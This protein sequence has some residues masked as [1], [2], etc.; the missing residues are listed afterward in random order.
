MPAA[1]PCEGNEEKLGLPS[2]QVV[3]SRHASIKTLKP[4]SPQTTAST[5]ILDPVALRHSSEKPKVKSPALENP[6]NKH[7]AHS[8][9]DRAKIMHEPPVARLAGNVVGRHKHLTADM[10]N[11]DYPARHLNRLPEHST[12]AQFQRDDVDEPMN[13]RMAK[14]AKKPS[15]TEFVED[16]LDAA[17]AFEK[18]NLDNGSFSR[19]RRWA[20]FNRQYNSPGSAVKVQCWLAK[21]KDTDANDIKDYM[22][23]RMSQHDGKAKQGD[24]TFE[25]LEVALRHDHSVREAE[26]TPTIVQQTTVCTWNDIPPIGT[27]TGVRMSLHEIVH[28]LPFPFAK[29]VFTVLVVSGSFTEQKNNE[30][31]NNFYVVSIPV[32]RPIKDPGPFLQNDESLKVAAYTAVEVVLTRADGKV[33]WVM[34]TD[35][36]PGGIPR[37][38]KNFA[39]CSSIANDVGLVMKWIAGRRPSLDQSKGA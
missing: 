11:L 35:S 22:A 19:S 4:A 20:L 30:S 31:Q 34:A 9:M 33:D 18:R 32:E 37:L 36:D 13:S 8:I 23:T 17:R 12:L 7:E 16:A 5:L 39:I 29:R 26:Y 38:F 15:I 27:W 6:A 24:A 2:L 21:K 1:Y 14:L 25:E 3:G 28:R 10:L